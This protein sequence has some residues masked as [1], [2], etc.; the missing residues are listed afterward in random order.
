MHCLFSLQVLEK[1]DLEVLDFWICQ[2]WLFWTGIRLCA[3]IPVRAY[4]HWNIYHIFVLS[5]LYVNTYINYCKIDEVTHVAYI[6]HIVHFVC[7]FILG[8]SLKY[9]RTY[10]WNFYLDTE[11]KKTLLLVLFCDIM[12]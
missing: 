12:E 7:W 3:S 1:L 4:F 10:F 2:N 6:P 9:L 8:I 5:Y 11:G